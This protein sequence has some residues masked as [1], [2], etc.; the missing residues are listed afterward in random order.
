MLLR[1]CPDFDPRVVSTTTGE[2][3]ILAVRFVP[4]VRRY[5]A[6]DHCVN[7]SN[8]ALASLPGSRLP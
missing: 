1:S 8:S 2:P 5:E 3:I 6:M 4:S 7:A